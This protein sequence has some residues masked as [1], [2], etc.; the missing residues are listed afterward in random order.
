MICES[1]AEGV[2]IPQLRLKDFSLF[3]VMFLLLI[4]KEN[5]KQGLFSEYC[6][7]LCK[8]FYGSEA[9]N[10]TRAFSFLVNCQ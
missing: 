6:F 5:S 10:E 3:L 7:L 2:G 9:E 1:I 8:Y 4:Y